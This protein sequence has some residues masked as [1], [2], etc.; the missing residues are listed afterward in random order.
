MSSFRILILLA[1][2]VA[3]IAQP[4]MREFKKGIEKLNQI[5]DDVSIDLTDDNFESMMKSNENDWF[6]YFYAVGCT[7]CAM[8]NPQWKFFATKVNSK[9]LPLNVAK[10]NLSENPKLVR[11]YRVS[12]FP[13]YLYFTGG[14][15][16]NY[17]GRAEAPSLVDVLEKKTY[18]MYDRHDIVEAYGLLDEAKIYIKSEFRK[19]VRK[20]PLQTA[21]GALVGI[22]A[23]IGLVKFFLKRR[24]Q[25]DKVE[26]N[27]K[28]IQ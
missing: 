2:L 5:K 16:Y 6:V 8:L 12:S 1:C 7:K 22:A 3:S 24:K 13:T 28:K 21:G 27:D 14:S 4:N 15:Y 11:R 25:D 20:Y 26:L 18:L 17:T 19:Y 23:V 10:I 9:E